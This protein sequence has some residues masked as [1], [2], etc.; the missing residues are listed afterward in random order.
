MKQRKEINEIERMQLYNFLPLIVSCLIF[1][2]MERDSSFDGKFNVVFLTFDYFHFIFFFIKLVQNSVKLNFSSNLAKFDFQIV[3]RRCG[4]Y[5][6]R[7]NEFYIL[8]AV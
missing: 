3:F 7:V 8:K 2:S 6:L 4:T 5:L 1:R